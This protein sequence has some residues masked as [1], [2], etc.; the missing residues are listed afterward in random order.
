MGLKLYGNKLLFSS[1]PSIRAL[2][3]ILRGG[4]KISPP[5]WQPRNLDPVAGRVKLESQYDTNRLPPAL[6]KTSLG[7]WVAGWLGGWVGGG[8]ICWDYGQLSPAEAGLG[9]SLTITGNNTSK[10][11]RS[12]LQTIIPYGILW[13]PILLQGHNF[14]QIHCDNKL[15]PGRRVIWVPAN[16][17]EQEQA[18]K[19]HYPGKGWRDKKNCMFW[20][21]LLH[22]GVSTCCI[23][24]ICLI[25][26]VLKD[27][28]T[29]EH[30]PGIPL[31]I[32]PAIFA[33][34]SPATFPHI[35]LCCVS[36]KWLYYDFFDL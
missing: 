15:L 19:S 22:R 20:T 36:E 30:I 7:G 18:G 27:Q 14:I 9:L 21:W 8:W 28:V 35:N 34:I 23:D 31:H 4:G 16:F 10:V 12:L 26:N 5:Q 33:H 17:G 13:M 11:F 2:T 1:C 6:E 24:K 25:L 3:L 29:P 32:S